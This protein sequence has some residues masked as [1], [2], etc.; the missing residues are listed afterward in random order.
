M[1]K[2]FNLAV[3]LATLMGA[4]TFTS[5][6]DD[7]DGIQKDLN[8]ER[9]YEKSNELSV[10]EGGEYAAY[11]Q[12]IDGGTLKFKVTKVSGAAGSK[13][14]EFTVELKGDEANGKTFTIGDDADH[15]SYF[16]RIDG[17]LQACKQAVAKE[18]AAN[19]IFALSS[20]ASDYLITSA[21]VNNGVK[22]AGATL[23]TF[24]TAK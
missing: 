20:Q 5:C 8:N 11:N 10:V 14:V 6:D 4:A 15:A 1:K 9:K 2:I 17:K 23:T 13:V 7:E 24:G 22:E 19:I 18:N 16:G 3:I 12:S 21:T